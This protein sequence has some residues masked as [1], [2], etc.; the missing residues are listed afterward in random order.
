MTQNATLSELVSESLRTTPIG[1]SL[2]MNFRGEPTPV[3][4]KYTFTGGWVVTQVLHPGVPL[5]LVKGE[6]GHLLQVDITLLPY[7]GLKVTE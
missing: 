1:K 5:E 7:D 3:E 4:V 6:D 2:I